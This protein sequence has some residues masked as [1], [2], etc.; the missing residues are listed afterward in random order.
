MAETKQKEDIA[1]ELSIS[2]VESPCL[3]LTPGDVAIRS[4]L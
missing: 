2:I 4:V 1:N 3:Q